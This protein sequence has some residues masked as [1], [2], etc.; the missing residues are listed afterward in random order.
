M[1]ASVDRAGR[2]QAHSRTVIGAVIGAALVM[3]A[4][5]GCGPQTG[6]ASP[7]AAG[8]SRT[9]SDPI[10]S[11]AAPVTTASL[12]LL[13][14]P[15]AGYGPLYAAI[16][17]ARSSIDLVLY[18]LDDPTA[19]AA[20]VATH[21]RGVTIRVLLDAAFHG[22]QTNQAAYDQ[23]S[24][25]GVDVHWAPPGQI[26]HE[27]A[28]VIDSA[29]AWIGTGNLTAK[30]YSTTRDAWIVDRNAGQVRAVANTFAADWAS[31]HHSGNSVGAPG[32]VWSPGAE[33]QMTALI[34][35]ARTSVDF[36]S[37]ELSDTAIISALSAAARRGV[38]CRIVMT[39]SADWTA[40]FRAVTAAG[41]AVHAF[42]DTPTALYVHEKLILVDR[43][44]VLLGSQN[45]TATSLN[46]N[47]ELSINIT[48]PTVVT[49]AAATFDADYR[50]APTWPAIT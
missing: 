39:D 1:S 20:L 50:A 23:L 35:T 32:L 44:A 12:T 46:R 13:Q 9:V 10:G 36:T 21:R 28:M 40:A 5:T 43:A 15:A 6:G 27:K 47:R 14:E 7:S 34:R 49:A 17:G 26:F 24:A 30:Y 19:Q 8:Q 11:A 3:L 37:E 42:P 31:P 48:A 38:T 33:Q 25:A 4:G 45:A 18:E 2:V 16:N 41:C 29:V 22:Q